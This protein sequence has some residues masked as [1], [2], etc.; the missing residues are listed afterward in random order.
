MSDFGDLR[1]AVHQLSSGDLGAISDVVYVLLLMPEDQRIE[2][3]LPYVFD[4]TEHQRAG[5]STVWE[6]VSWCVEGAAGLRQ[7]L[8]RFHGVRGHGPE[9]WVAIFA[10]A[11][12]VSDAHALG[13][14]DIHAVSAYQSEDGRTYHVTLVLDHFEHTY[15][16]DKQDARRDLAMGKVANADGS[17]NLVWPGLSEHVLG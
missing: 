8:S 12:A 13:N 3:G 17:V 14:I 9:R 7:H 11:A 5:R 4:H 2:Q 10:W 1:A 15:V 16:L 6:I